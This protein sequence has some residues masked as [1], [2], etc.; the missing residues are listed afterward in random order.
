MPWQ[1]QVSLSKNPIYLNTKVLVERGP[2][3]YKKIVDSSSP[4]DSEFILPGKRGQGLEEQGRVSGPAKGKRINWYLSSL[5]LE[6]IH[7]HV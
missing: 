3:E 5:I 1:N 2:L 7:Y 4:F 6:P